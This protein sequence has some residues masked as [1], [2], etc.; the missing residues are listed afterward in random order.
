MSIYNIPNKQIFYLSVIAAILAIIVIGVG[1]YTRLVHAGLGCPDWPGCY[2][3]LTSP[4]TA[5]EISQ[6]MENFPGIHVSSEK[7]W[8]EMTHRY[9]AGLLLIVIAYIT[10]L[11]WRNKQR[12]NYIFATGIL[13]FALLQAAFGMWT[14]TLKLWPQVV[15]S[16]LLGGMILSSLLVNLS[17]REY[18]F[19]ASIVNFKVNPSLLYTLKYLASLALFVVFIQIAIGGWTSANYSSLACIDFP[20]CQGVWLPNMDFAS[21]FN[22]FLPLGDNY[23]GGKLDS[24]ARTAIHMTHRFGAIIVF[25]VI[26]LLLY[27]SKKVIYNLGKFRNTFNSLLSIIGIIMLV[28]I[29]LGI[30]NVVNHLPL[31]VAVT[32][33]V[34]ASLLLLSLVTYNFYIRILLKY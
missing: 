1:A 10:V 16:H 6:A 31:I 4:S 3:L 19:Y 30:S 5:D 29:V 22:L 11:S 12:N 34:V 20:S 18:Y 27:Q 14:V 25:I 7:G 24:A 23:L 32:H 2:G 9:I 13:L 8:V 28:Q 26:V 33:T 21:G 15:V 17:L